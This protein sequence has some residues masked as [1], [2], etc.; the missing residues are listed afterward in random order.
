MKEKLIEDLEA[1]LYQSTVVDK[2]LREDQ[3]SNHDQ[4]VRESRTRIRQLKQNLNSELLKQINKD[5]P[6]I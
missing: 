5:K 1:E 3:N 2:Q 4:F 6:L